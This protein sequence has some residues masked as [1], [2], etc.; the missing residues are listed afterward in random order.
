MAAQ[1]SFLKAF[2]VFCT[3]TD[4]FSL[5]LTQFIYIYDPE[6]GMS[7]TANHC[8]LFTETTHHYKTPDT[9]IN[10]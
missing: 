10:K 5:S 7:I 4:I 9:I 8:F 2:C 6:Y 3:R 1:K